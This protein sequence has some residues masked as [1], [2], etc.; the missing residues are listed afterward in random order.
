MKT[1]N[2]LAMVGLFGALL[3]LTACGLGGKTE[4]GGQGEEA[5]PEVTNLTSSTVEPTVKTTCH[6]DFSI[7]MDMPVQYHRGSNNNI[8][9]WYVY[10]QTFFRIDPNNTG[11]CTRP[12]PSLPNNFGMG[13]QMN[14]SGLPAFVVVLGDAS[15]EGNLIASD[16]S[17]PGQE[18]FSGSL[19]MRPFTLN[20][21]CRGT[22]TF[23][24][25]HSQ[26]RTVATGSLTIEY[27]VAEGKALGKTGGVQENCPL[28]N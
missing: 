4:L 1:N 6:T 11:D 9:A 28:W 20:G 10:G 14:S 15:L 12:N 27:M 24:A 7:T 13:G 26:G 16:F 22:Y 19:D 25:Q 2:K 21:V 23:M 18:T 17:T 8:D 5:V 3:C